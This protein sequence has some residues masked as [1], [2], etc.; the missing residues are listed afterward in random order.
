[1]QVSMD[2]NKKYY[3]LKNGESYDFVGNNYFSN[4]IIAAVPY[5]KG[6]PVENATGFLNITGRF[7]KD[8]KS[9]TIGSLN[10]A[11]E[12]NKRFDNSYDIVKVSLNNL[13]GA[14]EVKVYMIQNNNASS[15]GNNFNI[16]K[17]KGSYNA[18]TNEPH[19]ENG[20]GDAGDFYITVV[21][22][23]NNPTGKELVVHEIIMYN[24]S[25]YQSGGMISNTDDLIVAD[26]YVV[27]DGQ[28][29]NVGD[30]L[31]VA[32][33]KLQGQIFQNTARF[34]NYYTKQQSDVILSKA[35]APLIK[36]IADTYTKEETNL[37]VD[38]AVNPIADALQLFIKEYIARSFNF[39][40]P[41]KSMTFNAS[42]NSELNTWV[43][44]GTATGGSGESGAIAQ[45][46]EC[47]TSQIEVSTTYDNTNRHLKTKI[48]LLSSGKV[49]ESTTL[50]VD[51]DKNTIDVNFNQSDFIFDAKTKQWSLKEHPQPHEY[52]ATVPIVLV[53]NKFGLNFAEE[54]FKVNEDGQLVFSDEFYNELNALSDKTDTAYGNAK[55]AL[56]DAEKAQTT[57]NEAIDSL[58]VIDTSKI[59]KLIAGKDIE[60]VEDAENKG[61]FTIVNTGGGGGS[62]EFDKPLSLNKDIVS[63]LFDSDYFSI[64]EDDAF[65]ISDAFD[66]AIVDIRN[67]AE[68]AQKMADKAQQDATNAITKA[69]TAIEIANQAKTTADNAMIEAKSKISAIAT[70]NTSTLELTATI[71]ANK[72][73]TIKG[74]VLAPPIPSSKIQLYNFTGNY[75]VIYNKSVIPTVSVVTVKDNIPSKEISI[76]VPYILDSFYPDASKYLI[77]CVNLGKTIVKVKGVDTVV[78]KDLLQYVRVSYDIA[79]PSKSLYVNT[80]YV[81]FK[82]DPTVIFNNQEL[83]N[84]GQ[85]L[86]NITANSYIETNT[87]Q[88][89]PNTIDNSNPDGTSWNKTNGNIGTGGLITLSPQTTLIYDGRQTNSGG[90]I[91]N[92]TID[93]QKNIFSNNFTKNLLFKSE[94]SSALPETG[95]KIL[96]KANT[97]KDIVSNITYKVL[98]LDTF[99]FNFIMTAKTPEKDSKRYLSAA[100]TCSNNNIIFNFS[101]F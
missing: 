37:V 63:F 16:L 26:N 67:T 84:Y 13:V 1:M 2:I 70:E 53:D 80:D 6:N 75:N 74:N 8:N 78:S 94:V 65:T 30:T 5:L 48:K 47:D 66:D 18:N 22:G 10:I 91:A 23:S 42:W 87:L 38:N 19:L 25:I 77:V 35:L 59:K 93:M 85:E 40:S 21:K 17:L 45:D 69:T 81:S 27:I 51:N 56:Q 49:Y 52:G 58:P 32:L 29:I 96:V 60:L 101:Q 99:E 90:G 68:Q 57:A 9:Q 82:F 95:L 14:D 100:M 43:A 24:G 39:T 62:Y 79:K 36:R 54:L 98:N 44:E 76:S 50:I 97:N 11:N 20:I 31:T 71:D 15:S 28:T 83:C 61:F 34:D 3:I 64:N 88:D 33:G 41:D 55:Q 86:I 73:V 4:L 7:D 12:V 92:F 72:K 89:Y 46:W